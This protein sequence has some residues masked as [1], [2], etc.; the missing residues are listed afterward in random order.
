MW[1]DCKG[2]DPHGPEN[3]GQESCFQR[4]PGPE[5]GKETLDVTIKRAPIDRK[6]GEGRKKRNYAC[7]LANQKNQK[8]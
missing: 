6:E 4:I 5:T 1:F 7:K 8:N 3:P 2:L